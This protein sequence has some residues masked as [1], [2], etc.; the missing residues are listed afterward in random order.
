MAKRGLDATVSLLKHFHEND[1]SAPIFQGDFGFA[2]VFE[3]LEKR[4]TQ[5]ALAFDRLYRSFGQNLPRSFIGWGKELERL[6]SKPRALDYFE[7]A[8]TLDPGNT[9]T[10]ERLKALREPKKD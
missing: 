6:G 5:E 10:A 7:K 2:L 4:Q 1:P 8:H 3:L 9:E